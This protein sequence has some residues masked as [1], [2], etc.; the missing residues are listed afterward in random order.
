MTSPLDAIE[1]AQIESLSRLRRGGTDRDLLLQLLETSCLLELAKLESSRLDPLSYLQLSVDVI[2]QMFPVE[3]CSVTVVTDGLP[4]THVVAGVEPVRATCYRSP[5]LVGEEPVGE[6]RIGETATGLDATEFVVTVAAQLSSALASVVEAERLRRAAATADA[7][8]LA[9]GLD[10]REPVATLEELAEYLAAFPGVVAAE[11][12]V[13]HPALGAPLAL[14]AGF[15][16]DDGHP[17]AVDTVSRLA[18]DGRLAVTLRGAA[19]VASLPA[20]PAVAEVLEYLSTSFERLDRTRRLQEEVETDPLTG[21]G[22]RRRLEH[23]LGTALS[24]ADRF[25][26][27]VALLLLDLDGFK[28]VNDNLG[29]D[30]GDRVLCA[31]ARALREHLRGYDEAVR[32]GG[33]E[34]VV[35]APTDDVFGAVRLGEHMRRAIVRECGE[36]LPE[37]WRVTASVG[38]AV[39]PDSALDAESL[40]RAADEALYRA[41]GA[42]RDV[43]MLADA[44][45]EEEGFS[46]RPTLVGSG[47]EFAR[48]RTRR[49]WFRRRR[50]AG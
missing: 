40:L 1:A 47:E 10:E 8:R 33:D 19:G 29:H 34:M 20:D 5:L 26:E 6:L 27:R 32:L 24:R 41:K 50:A 18:G 9:A 12:S 48:P 3:G 15:W 13:D 30:V 21:L 17:H 42:G 25:G 49:P 23:S 31:C 35:L 43:V 46:S 36:E 14:R 7:A 4:R 37:D 11:L 38:V 28:E 44:L 45:P 22:N 39:F 2:S 16:D